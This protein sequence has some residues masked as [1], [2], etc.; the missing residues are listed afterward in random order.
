MT[1]GISSQLFIPQKPFYVNLIEFHSV[2]VQ[3]S[4]LLTIVFY[5]DFLTFPHIFASF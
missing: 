3:N 5:T 1:S 4:F 2:R